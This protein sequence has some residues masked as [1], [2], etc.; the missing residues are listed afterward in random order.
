ML[1]SSINNIIYEHSKQIQESSFVYI[2]INS[3]LRILL[4]TQLLTFKFWPFIQNITSKQ[5]CTIKIYIQRYPE[6]IIKHNK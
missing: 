3:D 5:F 2:T 4:A 1:L 6:S